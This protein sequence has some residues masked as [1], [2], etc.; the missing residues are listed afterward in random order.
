MKR[1]KFVNKGRSAA[2]FRSQVGK[3]KLPNMKAV[4]RGGIRL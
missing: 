1:R 3:T 4:S 2:H